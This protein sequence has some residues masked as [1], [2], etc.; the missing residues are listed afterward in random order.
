MIVG[1]KAGNILDDL[2]KCQRFVRIRIMQQ[3]SYYVKRTI[4]QLFECLSET[5]NRC[6]YYIL[7]DQDRSVSSPA[8]TKIL[9]A[10]L[11]AI[12]DFVLFTAVLPA[13]RELFA[14][15]HIVLLVRDNVAGLAGNCPYVDE[16]WTLDAGK[17]K[18]NLA[19][20]LR[21]RR[22]LV[23]ENF[24]VAIHARYS[25]GSERYLDCLAAWCRAPRRIAFECLYERN[26]RDSSNPYYPELVPESGK[27][28]FEIDRNYDMVRYLGFA[29]NPTHTTSVWITDGDR[30][31]A[32]SLLSGISG[33]S[34]AVLM[35]GA[36][37]YERQWGAE[38]FVMAV[39]EI[40]AR[41]RNISWL[42]CGS[43]AETDLCGVIASHLSEN[44]IPHAMLAG[45]TSLRDL[46]V[47]I[48]GA[49]FYLG[50][51]TSGAHIAASVGVP[52]LC[53]LGGGHYGRFFPYP[54]NPL[55]IGITNLLSCYG[56]NWECR[57]DEFLC[58]T[59][60]RVQKVVA[61]VDKVLVPNRDACRC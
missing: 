45:K 40:N 52:A 42:L 4:R 28:R 6:L 36:T 3:I 59:G 27:G 60:I 37:L 7:P 47:L 46:A 17:F 8:P 25:V 26:K 32:D 15:A 1:E 19:E 22:R 56:C 31:T 11:D 18:V 13:Y 53:I 39:R 41:H 43:A 9:L 20:R 49:L 14:K 50:N 5:A 58:I 33:K 44:A 51:E 10:K 35:P 48:E 55:T 34:Y 61:E 29:G 16:V 21:W 30:T 12:G 54:G 38:N 23:R 24:D 57:Y 2:S